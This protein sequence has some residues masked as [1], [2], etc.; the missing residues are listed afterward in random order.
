MG[1]H[2]NAASARRN[3][4]PSAAPA[5]RRTRAGEAKRALIITS[6]L[7]IF[8]RYGYHGAALDQIAAGADL[9][10]TNLLYYFSSKEA[11]YI[12]VLKEIL[13]IWLAPLQVFVAGQQPLEAIRHYIRLKLEISRQHPQASR[14]FCLE[15][16]QGGTLLKSELE[17]A[18]KAIVDQKSAVIAA[19]VAE[20][21]LAAVDPHHLI[22]MLWATTQHY[23]DFASQIEAVTGKTLQDQEFFE[24]TVDNVQRM[25]VDGLQL[26]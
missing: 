9:S 25:I 8:S 26:R 2:N 18:L 13:A 6:A 17:G 14:L 1:T 15:I 22:F 11:L 20:G 24:S 7:S 16:I 12:A 3:K 19:W 4:Q 21:K 5:N 23:A 10:K